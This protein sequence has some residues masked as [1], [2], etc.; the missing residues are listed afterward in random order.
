M[1]LSWFVFL[2]AGAALSAQSLTGRWVG[3][4][5]TA[6]NGMEMVVALTQA[7]DGSL[8]GYVLGRTTDVIVSGKAEGSKASFQAERPGRGGNVQ[9]VVYSAVIEGDRLKLT[10]PA[11]RRGAAP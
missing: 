6:D 7:A 2:A 11:A 3:P 10:L 8:S 9:K 1:R 5:T 4:A